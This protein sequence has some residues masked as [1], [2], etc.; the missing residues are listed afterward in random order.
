MLRLRAA[1]GDW[2]P[3]GAAAGAVCGTY[4]HGLFDHQ[5]PRAAFLNGLRAVRG[6]APRPVAPPQD[7]ALER[8]ADHVEAYLDA[9]VLDAVIWG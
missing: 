5:A 8:L 1:G 2:H 3:D 7:D 9:E 4:L 6:L